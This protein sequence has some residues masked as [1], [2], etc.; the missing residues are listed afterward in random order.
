MSPNDIIN[1]TDFTAPVKSGKTQKIK[2]IGVGG[3]GNNAVD[4]MYECGIRD[5]EFILIN[6]DRQVLDESP[7]PTKLC[8][9]PGLGAG[10][11]P[12]KA[13]NYAEEDA[14]KIA[15]LFD[16]NTDMVFV[17]AGLGGGT[18]TGAAPVVAR[19]A[20]QKGILTVGIVTIP[21]MFEGRRKVLK[22]L[23]GAKEM[24][25]SVD[26]MLTIRNE[27]LTQIYPEL[28]IFNAFARADDT[29]LNAAKGI[30]DI[31]TI[32]GEINRDF[33]DV[34]STLRE[35]GT[36]IISTGYGSGENRVRAAIDEALNSP[37]LSNTDILRSKKLL[38]VLYV[39][40]DDE[41][42][43]FQMSE[44]NQLTDFVNDIDEEVD[45]MWGLYKDETLEDKVKI[46]ILA[47]GFDSDVTDDNPTVI[48]NRPVRGGADKKT[49]RPDLTDAYGVPVRHPATKVPVMN[50]ADYDNE[51]AIANAET[52]T[53]ERVPRHGQIRRTRPLT[54]VKVQPATPSPKPAQPETAAEKPASLGN[55]GTVGKISF[56]DM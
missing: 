39:N 53:T 50:P 36:A 49:D 10:G 13:R 2:V 55:N 45:V 47:S 3:G 22:A 8:I 38:I 1:S 31:I 37:L 5:V 21:F 7:V 11:K 46:T 20:K 28:S 18:G 16:D 32:R 54:Q 44:T 40:S 29:L 43:P 48:R 56:D 33:N 17:T 12:E 15:A 24:G 6:T 27:R 41:A 30:T 19:I 26:A 9:G 34:D 52:P 35:G 23:D 42:Y 14:E 51:E 25:A 4:H